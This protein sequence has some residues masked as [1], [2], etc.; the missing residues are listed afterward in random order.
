MNR[1]RSKGLIALAACLAITTSAFGGPAGKN[2]TT[3]AATKTIDICKVDDTTYKYS[4]VVSVW[5]EGA[6]DTVGLN[7]TDCIQF[8]SGKK[9]FADVQATCQ[10][11]LNGGV[12]IPSGTTQIDAT[13]FNYESFGPAP[14]ADVR[15]IARVKI[16]NHS[17]SIGK[18]T[19]PEPKATWTGGEI[20]SCQQDCGGPFAR[21]DVPSCSR[22]PELEPN[23][24]RGCT[25][26]QGYWGSGVNPQSGD[27]KHPWPSPFSRDA[28]FWGNAIDGGETY[29]QVMDASAAGGNAFYQLAHQYIAALLN[30]QTEVAPEGVQDTVAAAAAW[31]Q[32]GVTPSTCSADLCGIQVTWAGT[33]AVYNE[34]TYNVL[35][36]PPHCP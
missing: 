9:G 30:V 32:T 6:L 5:N 1:I 16:L 17:G 13:V 15:N 36:S 19:G 27:D 18:L 8:W 33:L 34:G 35:T 20:P 14:T 21:C 3:L 28:Y 23:C 24:N 10:T 4:G 31:F 22:Y 25:L 2:A 11:N 29:Q 12:Q 26:T 7:I